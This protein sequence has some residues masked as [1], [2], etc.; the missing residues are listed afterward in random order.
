MPLSRGAELLKKMSTEQVTDPKALISEKQVKLLYRIL[1][2]EQLMDDAVHVLVEEVNSRGIFTYQEETERESNTAHTE[3][4][5]IHNLTT[6]LISEERLPTIPKEI[7]EVIDR[8]LKVISKGEWDIGYT[9][10]IEHEIHLEYDRLIKRPVRYVNPRLADWL[11]KELERMETM[12]V[13][14]KSCSPYAS[15]ITIVEV[16]KADR[17]TKI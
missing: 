12:Q 15:L 4:K 3:V 16:E 11:K 7:Q 13:I 1:K 9:D 5:T 6:N 10:L 2:L 14:Q 8:Y 17:T